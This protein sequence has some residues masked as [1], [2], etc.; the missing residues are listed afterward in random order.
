METLSEDKTK[1]V[2]R[3]VHYETI[4]SSYLKKE[5]PSNST[6]KKRSAK[7]VI[8]V[9]RS[10]TRSLQDCYKQVL[11]NNPSLKGKIVVRFEIDQNGVVINSSLVSS[12]INNPRMENCILMRVK[13]WRDFSSCDPSFGNI[14]YRQKFSFGK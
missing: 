11:K 13:H 9:V 8:R 7:D 4:K 3:N 14:T 10:H 5:S 2:A 1:Q 12:T 6:K